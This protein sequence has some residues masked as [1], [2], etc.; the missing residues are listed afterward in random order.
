MNYRRR[1]AT[2]RAPRISYGISLDR[3]GEAMDSGLQVAANDELRT[4]NIVVSLDQMGKANTQRARKAYLP[5]RRPTCA[6]LLIATLPT[7]ASNICTCKSSYYQR[8]QLSRHLHETLCLCTHHRIGTRGGKK[9]GKGNGSKESCLWNNQDL[10]HRIR[11]LASAHKR[12]RNY[13]YG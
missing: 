6:T 12:R 13:M 1:R 8:K 10:R 7:S 11:L 2:S 5:L 9:R 4:R 3:T